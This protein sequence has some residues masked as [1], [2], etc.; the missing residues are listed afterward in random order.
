[1][2]LKDLKTN[3]KS[4]KFGKDRRGGG[5]SGQPYIQTEIPE[6]ITPDSPDFLYR[7]GILST[8]ATA[9]DVSRISQFLFDTKSPRGL[10]FIAKQELLSRLGAKTQAQTVANKLAYGG[11]F[12]NEGAYSPLSTIAQIALVG[13]GGHLYKQ[14][15]DPSGLAP[16]I[17]LGKYGEAVTPQQEASENRLVGFYRD[18]INVPKEG[19]QSEPVKFF[20]KISKSPFG[21]KVFDFLGIPP[22]DDILYSYQGGSG[23]PLGVGKTFIRTAS[24]RTGLAS[25][26]DFSTYQNGLANSTTDRSS[27]TYNGNEYLGASVLEDI[28]TQDY[29]GYS[30]LDGGQIKLYGFEDNNSTLSKDTKGKNLL[31]YQSGLS[32]STTDRSTIISTDLNLIDFRKPKIEDNNLTTSKNLSISPEYD[33]F[34]KETRLNQGDPGRSNT[35][36]NQKDVL[37]YG[38]PAEQLTALDKITAMPM[39]TAGGVNTDLAI[40]DIVKF[41]FAVINNDDPSQKTFVHFRAFIDSFDDGMSSDWSSHR[42]AGRG[43]SFYTYQGFERSIGIGFTVH[44]QSKA[45][46]IP[47]HTKL[48]YLQ[49]CMTPDYS[50]QG[51]M[52]GNI[53]Q[54][55]LG[56]YLY[57]VPCIIRSLNFSGML[58]GS[59]EIG[60][61]EDGTYDSSVKELPHHIKV[62]MQLNALHDF[63]P[64]KA[65]NP[66]EPREKFIS[67]T[68]GATTN[69]LKD[70]PLYSSKTSAN[71]R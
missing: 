15:L 71:N 39:Y 7:G 42:F 17:S 67:M 45:E 3:L 64:R 21:R 26:K 56:G 37:R 30:D 59:W 23:A 24:D 54:V 16:F 65:R 10:Q 25:G 4:L 20:G 1:M 58:E 36:D 18:K 13:S 32:N 70:Y 53:V 49:S 5:D 2:A 31:F 9:K 47:M 44:A 6:S 46:L 14:G 28:D 69:N 61:K 43:E 68:N 51:F 27:V 8:D 66:N 55:T 22:L 11:G 40:N 34:R 48:N 41:R 12:L 62:S 29:T 60:L 38:L 52:R 50:S 63:L 33:K 35:S 19:T 57:E